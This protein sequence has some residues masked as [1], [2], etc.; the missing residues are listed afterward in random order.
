[1]SDLLRRC[2]SQMPFSLRYLASQILAVSV[3][4]PMA[5]TAKYFP[6]PNSWPLKFYADRSF[7]TMRTDAL[8]R[9][10]TKLEKRFTKRQI[11]MMLESAGLEGVR[12]S[13]TEPHFRSNRFA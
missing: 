4:W 2:I 1:M 8:D 6:V 13:E 11:V 10:G 3:Y 9:F 7:Y 5:R 12:F